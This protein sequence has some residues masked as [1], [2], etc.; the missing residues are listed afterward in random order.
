[1]KK[2]IYLS[3]LAVM[4][5][6][7]LT[8]A[9]EDKKKKIWGEATLMALTSTSTFGAY[10]NTS[11]MM[12]AFYSTNLV[13]PADAKGTLTVPETLG[14]GPVIPLTIQTQKGMTATKRLYYWGCTAT[15]PKGQPEVRDNGWKM[16]DQWWTVNSTGMADATKMMGL[17]AESKVPGKYVMETNYTGSMS[18]TMTDT[19]QFLPPLKVVEPAGDKAD[20]SQAIPVKWEKVPGAGGYLVMAVGKNDKG[21]DVTWESAYNAVIWQRM[22]VTK[23]L[24]KGLLKGPDSLSCTIPAGIF[25]GQVSIIVTAVTPIATGEGAFSFW[26]WAQSANSKIVNMGS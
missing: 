4:C 6:S 15:V 25:K 11:Y 1:M 12:S 8:V 18:L 23:A 9:Q 17:T 13:P 21:E 24:E 2:L 14:I 19:Q 22:G 20:T 26:G 3:L 5:L 10:T 16:K 7:T